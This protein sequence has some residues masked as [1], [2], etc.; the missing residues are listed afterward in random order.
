MQEYPKCL[1]KNGEQEAETASAVDADAEKE[2][3]KAGFYP[4]GTKKRT[5]K[6][7]ETE[8]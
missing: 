8:E 3:A 6:A 1:Y 5:K 7:D 4:L 2:L